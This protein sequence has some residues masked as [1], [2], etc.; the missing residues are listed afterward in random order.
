LKPEIESESE[1]EEVKVF[2]I[3][4]PGDAKGM[5]GTIENLDSNLDTQKS[6][7]KFLKKMR[8]AVI[9]KFFPDFKKNPNFLTPFD[10]VK[11]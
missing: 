5:I 4:E 10:P 2:D 6:K 1:P 8:E 3:D 11:V 7:A 9:S